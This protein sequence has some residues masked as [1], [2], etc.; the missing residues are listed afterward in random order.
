MFWILLYIGISITLEFWHMR[1]PIH[2]YLW[3]C[4]S[5]TL[6]FGYGRISLC[7]NSD[8]LE[9]LL[10]SNSNISGYWHMGISVISELPLHQNSNMP[11]FPL[12]WNSLTYKF[13]CVG[14]IICQN[15]CNLRIFVILEFLLS[16]CHCIR[17]A[18]LSEFLLHLN[19]PF[20]R[21]CCTSI[22]ARLIFLFNR[23]A[24][25]WNVQYVR[26]TI[27]LEFH[28]IRISLHQNFVIS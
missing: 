2:W 8:T 10:N 28:Y 13:R 9:I 7:H 16:E 5:L 17:I 18:I 6:E 14:I 12:H 22:Y 26:I 1:I 4:S 15:F 23:I 19:F 24:L 11:K 27:R 20:I 3:Q 25:C 21:I